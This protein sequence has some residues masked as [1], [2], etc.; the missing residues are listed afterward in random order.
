MLLISVSIVIAVV[1]VLYGAASFMI[2]QGVTKAER[3]E[4]EGHPSE[5][6]LEFEEVEFPPRGGELTLRGWYM[7]PMARGPTIIL[8]HGLSGSRSSGDALGLASGLLER[9]FGVLTFDLRA[10]GDSEGDRVSGGLHERLDVLGAFDY[11][12]GRGVPGSQIG[13]LGRSMGA[14]TSILAAAD[15]PRIR[16]LV[17]DSPYAVGSELIAQETA[18]KTIF[19]EW[20]VPIFVRGAD[21]AAEISLGIDLDKLTPVKAIATLDYPVLVIHTRNDTRIPIEHG[22]RVHMA[23]H[24]DSELWIV[25]D[26]DA[27]H[28]DAYSMLPEEYLGR[29][30]GY[31]HERLG[32]SGR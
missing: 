21:I 20:V 18:R 28:G 12:I 23:S 19:P 13:V 10:H 29:V 1:L 11:L 15:E 2:A 5:Y 30:S 27:D 4:H 25:S 32:D 14:A 8:V 31:F 7:E 26:I 24:L 17:A 16:A 9:G 22:I 3:E 6:G